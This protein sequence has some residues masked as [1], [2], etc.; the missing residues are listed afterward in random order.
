MKTNFDNLVRKINQFEIKAKFE[1]TPKEK[2]TR[3]LKKEIKEY[4]TAKTKSKKSD[5]LID[6]I[7][8]SMQIA[9]R[10]NISLDAAWKRWWVKS[11][12]YLE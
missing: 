11:K 7:I 8:L 5:K 1:R 12:K 3:W 2:L 9:E 4:E 6:I 10:E